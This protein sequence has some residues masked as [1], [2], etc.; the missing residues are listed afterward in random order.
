MA[1][2]K[3]RK[4]KRSINY[5]SIILLSFL[6]VIIVGAGL[7]TLPISSKSGDWTDITTALFTAT[8]ATCVTGLI[9]VDTGTF[10][11]PFGKIVILI[12]IQ[13]G[14]LGIMTIISLIAIIFAKNSSLHSR[15][16]AMQAAGAVSYHTVYDILKVIFIGTAVCEFTGACI[17]SIRFIPKFG[18]WRGIWFSVFHSVSAF[19]NA[20]FDVF[21]TS[22]GSSLT[23][24]ASDPLVLI[25]IAALIIIGGIGFIVWGDVIKHGIHFKLYS[26]HSK[27][28]LSTTVALL[29]IGTGTMALTERNSAFEGMTIAEKILNAFFQSTTLRTAGFASVD[30]A[31][32][33][34]GGTVI[35]YIL[36]FIGGTSGSTAGGVKTTTFAIF[37]LTVI[38]TIARKNDIV[39]FKRRIADKT[40][41]D[42]C[43]IIFIYLLN[44]IVA[45]IAICTIDGF[46]TADTLFETVSAM[47]TV[48]LSR[49]ITASLSTAS[50]YIIIFLMFVGRIGG[51]SFILAF[52]S[53]KK[54]QS[55]D[56]PTGPVIIG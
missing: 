15:S 50:R 42:A 45:T 30:Q 44:V 40:I 33:S 7:L 16:L 6:L 49:G 23:Q 11:S 5:T 47:A 54:S 35:S 31:D 37:V 43:S 28:A 21:G 18:V 4:G 17:L 32:L 13:V 46:T 39:V 12:L 3:K 10:W 29:L 53:T 52:S 55:T 19:C 34:S 14:G 1:I 36:M 9:V 41:K 24:F 38:T 48:G 25:T 20:G 56:R 22:N 8:S 26:F 51:L 2:K 27:V